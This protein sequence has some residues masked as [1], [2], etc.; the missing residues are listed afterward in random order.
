VRKRANDDTGVWGAHESKRRHG[1]RGAKERANGDARSESV[2]LR[3][4]HPWCSQSNRNRQQQPN[5]MSTFKLVLVVLAVPR[6]V[7]EKNAMS[8]ER[9]H[10]FGSGTGRS[11]KRFG[12]PF[13]IR[14]L[15]SS[16]IAA[17]SKGPS[18]WNCWLRVG[19]G[20]I[21]FLSHGR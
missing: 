11:L 6:H 18:V 7:F 5:G 1:F 3:H 12:S 2:G 10:V 15:F 16:H 21:T 13:K 4:F 9:E 17:Y 19:L 14:L 8:A 20:Y